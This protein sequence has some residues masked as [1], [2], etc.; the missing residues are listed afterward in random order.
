[1]PRWGVAHI[2]ASYNNIIITLTDITGSE[3]ITKATGGM[4]VKAAKDEAS[5]RRDEGG[6]TRGGRREGE[7]DRLDPR[8]GPSAGRKPVE[9]SR[10]GGAGGDPGVVPCGPP[11]RSDRRG[12]TRASRWHEA[13]GR[14]SREAG[15]GEG[16]GPR[17]RAGVDAPADRGDGAVVRERSATRPRLRRPEDGDR[18]RREIG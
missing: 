15:L 11:D 5:V 4:V 13:Q 10:P 6:G 16:E 14:A 7:G 8:P 9:V 18:G 2:Y 3:T 12:H 1:M 17:R